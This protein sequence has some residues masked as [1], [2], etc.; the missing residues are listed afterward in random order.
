M[1][2]EIDPEAPPSGVGTSGEY[3]ASYD[4]E[5][6]AAHARTRQHAQASVCVCAGM[7]VARQQN[8][9]RARSPCDM[10]GRSCGLESAVALVGKAEEETRCPP[11][12]PCS[13][14]RS[15][16]VAPRKAGGAAR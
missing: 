9:R 4:A 16:E 1:T 6:R 7:P 5:D 8:R 2:K 11:G 14:H 10:R 13:M 15:L 3:T 12:C